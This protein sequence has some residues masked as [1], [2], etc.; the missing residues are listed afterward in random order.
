MIHD[1]FMSRRN[2]WWCPR[3]DGLRDGSH[4]RPDD[5]DMMKQ[6]EQEVNLHRNNKAGTAFALPLL[7][8]KPAPIEQHGYLV[9]IAMRSMLISSQPASPD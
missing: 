9:R 6:E 7:R 3:Q 2:T 4:P 8:L 1:S 5:H